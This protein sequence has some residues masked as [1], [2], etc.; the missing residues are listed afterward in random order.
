MRLPDLTP[1][2]RLPLVQD[3]SYAAR[4][5]TAHGYDDTAAW[6]RLR[7]PIG[8]IVR[9]QLVGAIEDEIADHGPWRKENWDA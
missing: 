6:D 3:P 2:D 5:P 8:H 1:L 7:S 9:D 4:Q